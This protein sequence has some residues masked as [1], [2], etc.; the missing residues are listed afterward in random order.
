MVKYY[1][2]DYFRGNLIGIHIIIGVSNRNG[3][4]IHLTIG[5]NNTH[6]NVTCSAHLMISV[7][8]KHGVG[9]HLM[10]RVS[11][12]HGVSTHLMISVS[13]K[14]G[15]GIHLMLSV[16]N[17]HGD[18]VRDNLLNKYVV[19]SMSSHSTGYVDFIKELYKFSITHTHAHTQST[20]FFEGTIERFDPR[21]G[22]WQ[23]TLRSSL[24][25]RKFN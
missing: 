3:V 23:S 16:S 15:V 20:I 17:K 14:H 7:S 13:N 25:R 11:N 1:H 24:S 8:N 9:T 22:A 2:H 5:V 18:L 10:I 4:I 21:T 19:S 6:M 12:K